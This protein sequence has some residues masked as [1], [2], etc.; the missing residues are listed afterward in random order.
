M[1]EKKIRWRS[2]ALVYA[3]LWRAC[4]KQVVRDPHCTNE[5]RKFQFQ[6]NPSAVGSTELFDW[7]INKK[8]CRIQAIVKRCLFNMLFCFWWELCAN[9]HN[10]SIHLFVGQHRIKDTFL[11]IY[12]LNYFW[13]LICLECESVRQL[14]VS[15]KSLSARNKKSLVSW[16]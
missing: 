2:V 7:L 9:Y 13:F 6:L 15:A 14:F 3:D 1:E 8:D 11:S 4:R 5:G 16:Q 12:V 10:T